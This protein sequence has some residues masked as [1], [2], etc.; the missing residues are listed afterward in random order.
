M[1]NFNQACKEEI[2]QTARKLKMMGYFL[3]H[4]YE[5]SITLIQ[6]LDTD[7]TRK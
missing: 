7:V 1:D 3:I 2:T 5:S 6:K 4:I